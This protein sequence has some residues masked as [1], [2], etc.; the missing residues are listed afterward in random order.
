MSEKKQTK[1]DPKEFMKKTHKPKKPTK[2]QEIAELTE[3]LKRTQAEFINYKNRVEKETQDMCKYSNAD[4]IKK[5]LPVLDSFELALKNTKDQKKFKEGVEM[6]YSQL[7]DTLKQEGLEPIN[8]KG[9]KF[10]PYMHE[11]MLKEKSDK[12]SDTVIEELQKGYMLK[13]KIIRHS[14]VKISE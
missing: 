1:K 12:P 8:A 9:Q 5:L 4:I 14:K 7:L 2:A 3:M 6:V 13:D 10:D 11:V